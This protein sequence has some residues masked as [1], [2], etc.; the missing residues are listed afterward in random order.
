MPIKMNAFLCNFFKKSRN[1][2]EVKKKKEKTIPQI[3]NTLKQMHP[4]IY[5]TGII[6]I[7]NNYF[8]CF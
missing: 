8:K 7:Q 3:E 1:I 5:P 2:S 4:V 6:T